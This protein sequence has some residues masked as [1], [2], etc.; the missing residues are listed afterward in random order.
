MDMMQTGLDPADFADS[1]R[2]AVAACLGLDPAGCGARLAEDGLL[3]VLA[4]EEVGGLGL[5]LRFALPVVQAAGAGDLAFP[6]AETMLMA[7]HLAGPAPAIA[8]SL[9]AG[10]GRGTIAWA[11]TARTELVGTVGRAPLAEG[12]D[13][14]LVR[15]AH[16]AALLPGSALRIAKAIGLDETAPEYNVTLTGADAACRLDAA[17][18]SALA[19]EASLLRAAAILGAAETSLALAVEH[20]TTRRQ[21]GKP[22]VA[23]QAMR[24]LLARQKLAMEGMRGALIRATGCGDDAVGMLARRAAFLAAATHGPLIAEA[25]IQ[26]HGGMGFTWDI[27]VHRHLRRIRTLEAQGEAP[28]M[29]EAVAAALIDAN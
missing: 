18:W 8:A 22:L 2:K 5:D 1:A 3:G 29:R 15:L 10:E 26:A 6:L 13:W 16:G 19:E 11:G 28:A 21:F 20:V 23:N 4:P 14:V 17:A 25:S 9:A 7:R 12:A 27:P 24:H